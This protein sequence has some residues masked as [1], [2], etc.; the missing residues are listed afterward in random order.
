MARVRG[1]KASDLGEATVSKPFGTR[2][3]L[4]YT[5]VDWSHASFRCALDRIL[6]GPCTRLLGIASPPSVFLEP[7]GSRHDVGRHHF[8][9]P[10]LR[11]V[12]YFHQRRTGLLRQPRVFRTESLSRLPRRSQG[13]TRERLLIRQ[14]RIFVVW[15]R[16]SLGRPRPARDVQR[17]LFQLRQ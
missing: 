15:R 10:R 12:I 11:S 13:A 17:Q 3:W 2:A 8:E 6:T 4:R 1:V 5:Q 7:E 14:L 9:L 16:V